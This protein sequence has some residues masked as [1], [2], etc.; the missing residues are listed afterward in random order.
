MGGFA[1]R[2]MAET[3]GDP[4]RFGVISNSRTSSLLHAFE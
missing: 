3:P 2:G 1:Q 4:L